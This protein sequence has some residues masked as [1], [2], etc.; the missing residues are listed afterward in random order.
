MGL[1]HLNQYIDTEK[2]K[3]DDLKVAMLAI[4][5]AKY[6]F[7]FDF[8]KAYFHVD[9]DR[10]VQEFFG[11]SFTYK[12]QRYYGHYTVAPFGLNTLPQVFTKLIKPL[13]GKW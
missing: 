13:V 10:E 5:Q 4:R 3:L 1:R 9:L 11:F 12:G 6:L 2:F 7:S 8:K